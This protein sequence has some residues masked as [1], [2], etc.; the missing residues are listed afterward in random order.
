VASHPVYAVNPSDSSDKRLVGYAATYNDGTKERTS[1]G[2]RDSTGTTRWVDAEKNPWAKGI[3]PSVASNGDIYLIPPA[4][5]ALDSATLLKQATALDKANGTHLVD[6]IAPKDP[7]ANPAGEVSQSFVDSSGAEIK[8]TLKNGQFESTRTTDD[9]NGNKTM[10][11][12][13]LTKIEGVTGTAGFAKPWDQNDAIA[14]SR[15]AAGYVPGVTESSPLAVS[16]SGTAV[17]SDQIAK[18]AGDPAFQQ[19]FLRQTMAAFNT[20]NPLDSRVV[21]AWQGL[22]NPEVRATNSDPLPRLASQRTDLN[23]PGLKTQDQPKTMP[24]SFGGQTLRVPSLPGYLDQNSTQGKRMLGVEAIATAVQG[25]LGGPKPA[26]PMAAPTSPTG[27]GF[28]PQPTPIA[29]PAPIAPAPIAPAPAP[30][31]APAPTAVSSGPR[32]KAL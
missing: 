25:F 23:V 3:V 19:S 8:V 12:Y 24:I 2:Y 1:Y 13:D 6:L 4:A 31:A 16:M 7:N 20:D 29:P 26:A 14:S 30:V 10:Q 32:L 11:A 18:L 27:G 28:S 22:T 15:Y 17:A 5:P 9:G 21:S